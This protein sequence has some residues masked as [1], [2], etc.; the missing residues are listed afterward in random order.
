MLKSLQHF[1][2]ILNN[3]QSKIIPQD[4]MNFKM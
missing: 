4:D 2:L 3:N 1:S